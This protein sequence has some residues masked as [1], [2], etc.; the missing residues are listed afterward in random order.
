M[1]QPRYALGN[2]DPHAVQRFGEL[3]ELFDGPSV[4]YLTAL[5]VSSGWSCWEVGA[6]SG[7]IARW[8]TAAVSPSGSVLATDL[9]LRRMPDESV[10]GLAAQ[11]HDV[12]SDESPQEA[13]DLVHARLVLVHLRDRER[14]LASLARSL[15]PGGWILIEDFDHAFLDATKPVTDQEASVRRIERAFRE[16]LTQ[17]GADM[18]YPRRLPDLLRA[19]GMHDVGGEGRMVFAA[20]ASPASRLL[21]ANFRQVGDELVSERLSTREELATAL[22][23]LDDP[24]C[25]FAMPLLVSA[26]GRRPRAAT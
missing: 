18:Q 5:G 20:G 24:E 23:L 16:L 2:A 19:L 17:R 6:G 14:V 15:R 4:E 10:A 7:S 8:L 3:E 11:V 26:W 9:D 22:E 13:F 21:K 12:V 25:G 1:T